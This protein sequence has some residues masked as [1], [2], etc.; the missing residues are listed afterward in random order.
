MQICQCM[1][2]KE[3]VMHGTC[4]HKQVAT[5]YRFRRVGCLTSNTE[6]L[7]L[8]KQLSFAMILKPIRMNNIIY[9]L[10]NIIFAHL[11]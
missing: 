1:R 6:C 3:Y 5:S 4:Q 11:Q 8:V 10:L 7:L 2:N 9:F